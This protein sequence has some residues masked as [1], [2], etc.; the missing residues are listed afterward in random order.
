MASVAERVTGTVA[1]L[2]RDKG[3][4]FVKSEEGGGECFFHRSSVRGGRFEDL[5]EGDRVEYT[6]SSSPKGPRAE[7][8]RPI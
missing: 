1:R 7:D 6:V 5:S 3:F 4:G 2:L 8:V